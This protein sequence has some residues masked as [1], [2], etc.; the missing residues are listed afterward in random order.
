MTRILDYLFL[1][2]LIFLQKMLSFLSHSGRVGNQIMGNYV[3]YLSTYILGLFHADIMGIPTCRPDFRDGCLW[4][5][6]KR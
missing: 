6:G 4:L 5:F 1:S 3:E 2:L